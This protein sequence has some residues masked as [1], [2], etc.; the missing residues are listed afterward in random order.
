MDLRG[1]LHASPVYDVILRLR[2]RRQYRLWLQGGLSF[3][4][5]RV[6]ENVLRQ[7]ARRHGLR[8][9]VET[10]TYFGEMIDALKEEFSQIQS[11]ELDDFLYE[12]A[13]R[14]FGNFRHI[15][16]L[17]GD[18]SAM[19]AVALSAI[20]GPTLFWLDA[21]HSAGITA[22]GGRASPVLEEL[23]HIFRSPIDGHVI[24]IDDARLFGNEAGY[25]TMDELRTF[26]AEHA[27]GRITEV[28]D[29]IIHIH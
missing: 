14:R 2:S 6:K 24:A 23:D 13:R 1:R 29:D 10:G 27:L 18:S 21:H 22:M 7:Y 16:L 20:D 12:R 25:P 11:I 26:V 17:H 5:H 9:F 3:P 19:L 28:A 4:P 8:S 15:H